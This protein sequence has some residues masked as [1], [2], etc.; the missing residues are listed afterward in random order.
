MLLAI[1]LISRSITISRIKC[2]FSSLRNTRTLLILISSKVLILYGS[3]ASYFVM[4]VESCLFAVSYILKLDSCNLLSRITNKWTV[5]L[6]ILD[7]VQEVDSTTDNPYLDIFAQ[8]TRWGTMLVQ[9]Y[10]GSKIRHAFTLHVLGNL[11]EYLC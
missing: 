11:F 7:Q 6:Y 4:F 1:A 9:C 5:L 3:K 8:G 2:P 10:H